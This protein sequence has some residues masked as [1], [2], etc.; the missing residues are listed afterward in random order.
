MIKGVSLH[1]GLNTV[2]PLHY[3]DEQG[4][5]WDGKLNAC[6]NDARDM[7]ALAE[8]QG[9]ST[10]LVLNSEATAQRISNE[11][12]LAAQ[13]LQAGDLFFMSYSGHGG[14]VW[15]NNN[16]EP[17]DEDKL[18]DM[19]GAKDETFCLYDRQF[20]DD[21]IYACLS[22][23]PAG[24]RVLVLSDE[25]HSGTVVRLVDDADLPAVR[26]MPFSASVNTVKAN[27][28]VY[29]AVWA[30]KASLQA[31]K[32]QTKS[33]VLLLS[34]C[35][36]NQLSRDGSHNGAFTGAVLKI[37][38]NGNFAGNYRQFHQ[39]VVAAIPAN[40]QQTPNYF[41]TGVTNA[42]FEQQKPFTI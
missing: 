38:Q 25:C 5:P 11:I 33:S 15:D 4:R 6:E 13:Q 1:I 3:Q 19:A 27:P 17:K 35:Q 21:E 40:Y 37:W 26:Q 24:V 20:L 9:F 10:T 14:Q 12:R 29:N 39:K 8:A 32:A 30:E 42:A 22:H 28:G 2:N 18:T 41:T 34:G 36:D 16:D 23:I 7:Q 31:A